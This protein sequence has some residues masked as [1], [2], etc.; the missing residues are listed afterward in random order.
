MPIYKKYKHKSTT[1]YLKRHQSQLDGVEFKET[2]P[3]KDWGEKFDRAKKGIFG[4]ASKSEKVIE[5]NLGKVGQK[6]VDNSLT[7]KIG[8]FLKKKTTT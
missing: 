1:Y 2:P 3:A 8:G 7:D 5:E 4:F 6:I